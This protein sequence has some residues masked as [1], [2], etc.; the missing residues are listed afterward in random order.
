MADPE[1]VTAMSDTPS[2]VVVDVLRFV[3]LLTETGL[4]VPACMEQ[5]RVPATLQSTI[6]VYSVLAATVAPVTGVQV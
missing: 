1:S 6:K 4:A 3:V 5:V 2:G